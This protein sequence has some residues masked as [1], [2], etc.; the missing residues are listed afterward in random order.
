MTFTIVVIIGFPLLLLLEPFLNSNINFVKIKPLF[1]HFQGCYKDKYRYFAAYYMI[2]RIVIIILIIAK[3]S[4]RVTTQYSVISACALMEF[5]HL[6]VKP[7]IGAVY[8][9][10]DGVILQL[11]AIVSVLPIVEFVNGDS[12]S[13]S[14]YTICRIYHH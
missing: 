9:I 7:Y 3:I 4:D 5:T 1:G 11:I 10:F 14:N 13:S 12:L 6:I 2:C 8:N